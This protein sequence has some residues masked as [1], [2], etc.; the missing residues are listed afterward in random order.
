VP[1][2]TPGSAALDA[3]S[4]T[5]TNE[6]GG[7]YYTEFTASVPELAA[8]RAACVFISWQAFSTNFTSIASVLWNGTTMS[9]GTP[10]STVNG[11]S[12]GFY[13]IGG[14]HNGTITIRLRANF[15]GS[16]SASLGHFVTVWVDHDTDEI[17]YDAENGGTVSGANTASVTTAISSAGIIFSA[18]GHD[19][20]AL[21]GTPFPDGS[22]LQEWDAGGNCFMAGYSEPGS[23][24]SYQHRHV[25]SQNGSG[26]VVSLAFIA[27]AGGGGAFALDLDPGAYTLT[28]APSDVTGHR[29]LTA[30]AGT[31]LL[32]GVAAD[33]LV[34]R[35][36]N[37]APG[38]YNYAGAN[39][40]IV[41]LRVLD[42]SVGLY[43]L[44][45]VAANLEVTELGGP[46]Y[47]LDAAP[48]TFVVSGVAAS[49]LAHRLLNAA[50]AVYTISGASAD[51]LARRVLDA[52]AGE[53]ASSGAPLTALRHYVL[54]AGTATY[55]LTGTAADFLDSSIIRPLL[56]Q[57]SQTR[58]LS[59]GVSGNLLQAGMSPDVQ[60]SYLASITL[61][62]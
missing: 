44:D 10:R 56:T 50:T 17:V 26:H 12:Q 37:A 58:L 30:N 35:V 9:A 28:G 54:N 55:T 21:D 5:W 18:S 4:P 11:L 31:F 36:L 29:I 25:Y 2:N 52:A 48:G 62:N 13:I 45:G 43:T 14:A 1:F 51:V 27:S 32:T 16:P 49:V 6:G 33:L 53:Y 59:A 23:A 7:V 42:T 8:N 40:Q 39:A 47:A 46:T 60:S 22:L 15:S 34:L 41:A 38:S 57:L 19:A 24:G 20:N 3:N 61:R